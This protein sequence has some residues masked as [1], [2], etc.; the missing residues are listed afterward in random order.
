MPI[1]STMK[2][3]AR[4]FLTLEDPPGVKLELVDG[5]VAVSPSPKPP[6]SYVD[7]KLRK[8]IDDYIE[9]NGLGEIYGD[10]DTVFGE[11]DVRRPDMVYF[12]AD[13]LDLVTD[14][15]IEG[16]P[17]LCIEIVSPSSGHID[18][19]DKFEQYA[20]GNVAHY[21]IVEPAKKT[22]EGFQLVRGKYELTG[23]GRDSDVIS[24]P[25][26]PELKIP[27][28]RLWRKPRRS[29]NNPS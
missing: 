11:H 1:V 17:D 4:Q 19:V 14:D 3:T 6:H 2:M 23:E 5:E 28:A 18:R 21:W 8:L 24:L 29:Q 20:A 9:A 25:P 16:P 10:M 15:G 7:T 12:A 22:L 27:L 26:F 13:R